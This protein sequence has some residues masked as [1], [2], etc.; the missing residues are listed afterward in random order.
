MSTPSKLTL[1]YFPIAGRAEAIRLA[2]AVGNIP[3]TN[4]ILTFPEFKAKKAEFPLGQVPILKLEYP[5]GETKTIT[6]SNAILRYIGKR[7]SL[8]PTDE[9][10]A[11]EVDELLEMMYDATAVIALTVRG[12]VNALINEEKDF[13]SEE[14]LGM[15]KRWMEKDLPKFFGRIEATLNESKSGWCVGDS[16]TIADLSAAVTF[17]WITSGVLDGIPKEVLD[18]YPACKALHEKVHNF[19][20]VKKWY[21]AYPKPYKQSFDYSP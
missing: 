17:T 14:K 9:V 8:Y 2:A 18:E 1:S 4:E 13:T 10:Q 15:R 20:A 19:P 3:F 21:D 11:L 12:A 5:S 6:Q 7:A 16:I